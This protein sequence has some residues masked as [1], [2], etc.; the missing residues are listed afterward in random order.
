MVLT[1]FLQHL[2][3]SLR[4]A[5]TEEHLVIIT[6]GDVLALVSWEGRCQ[7]H[8][9]GLGGTSWSFWGRSLCPWWSCPVCPGSC[10]TQR[11]CQHAAGAGLQLQGGDCLCS[12]G[13]VFVLEGLSLFW[14]D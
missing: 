10:Y 5:W 14:G 9:Q 3:R 2:L 1:T 7:D 4:A 12:G 11:T 13:A 6:W 8:V